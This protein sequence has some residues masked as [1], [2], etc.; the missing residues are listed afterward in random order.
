[1]LSRLVPNFGNRIPRGAVIYGGIA[2]A[3]STLAFGLTKIGAH[4]DEERKFV[5]QFGLPN[6]TERLAAYREILKSGRSRLKDMGDFESNSWVDKHRRRLLAAA[7]GRVLDVGVGAGLSLDELLKNKRVTEIVGVDIVEEALELAKTQL[8]PESKIPVS[9][10]MHDF[11]TLP[12]KDDSFDTVV[13][14][15]T[16]CSAEDPVRLLKEMH[17]V[18]KEKILLLDH[19]VSR[20]QPLRWLGYFLQLFPNVQAPWD[21]GCFEDR[22][23]HVLINQAGLKVVERRT[24]LLGHVYV[25]VAKKVKGAGAETGSLPIAPVEPYFKFLPKTTA[26]STVFL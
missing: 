25:L 17:R 1:M 4:T 23:I 20:F 9:L 16:L 15:F 7:K 24:V 18:S 21:V 10:V 2:L 12:F 14:C 3:G 6:E 11:H 5:Q 8:P 26:E 13:G 19:G 22:D